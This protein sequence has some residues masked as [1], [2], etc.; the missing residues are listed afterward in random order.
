MPK[1]RSIMDDPLMRAAR[2]A[3]ETKSV[4]EPTGEA[5]TPTKMAG[6]DPEIQKLA[7][8]NPIFNHP[9]VKGTPADELRAF[10]SLGGWTPSVTHIMEASRDY[11]LYVNDD[12]A[13]PYVGDGFKHVQR[14]ALWLMRN[15]ADKIKVVALGG[16]LAE[17]G[18]Y[19]HGDVSCNDAISRLAAPYLNNVC[20]LDG[21]GHFGSR[22]APIEGIGAARYVSVRRSK[23]AESFLYSDLATV[24]LTDNYDGSNQQPVHFLPLIPIV[25]LN[26]ISGMG[27]G[28]STN[29]L[30]HKLTDIIDAT[31]AVMKGK[32]IKPLL[33][34]WERYDLD[35]K[36]LGEG[37]YEV[38]G[39][40]EKLDTSRARIYE[41]PPGMKVDDFRSKLIEM[42]EKGDIV[43]FVDRSTKNINIEIT[44]K[45][46]SI[47]DWNTT[48]LLQFFKLSEKM[49][50]RLVV[51]S[52]DGKSITRIA[53][54]DALIREFV[55][56]RLGWFENRYHHLR[57]KANIE[58][59]Y[60]YLVRAMIKGGFTKKLGTFANKAAVEAEVLGIAKKAKLAIDDS[61]VD[62]A[63]GLPTYRWTKEFESEVEAKIAEIEA[64]MAE[65]SDILSKP[66]RRKA[67]YLGEVEA[68]RKLRQ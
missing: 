49:T 24:P 40:I 60:W 45:R 65:Y 38:W 54:T 13:I 28:Y 17:T 23:A 61:S 14:V 43:K 8:I 22:L 30:P 64:D 16:S 41:L 58:L 18:L 12:R 9:I 48:R 42:E 29:I 47:S 11:S 57:E 1:K 36:S 4:V 56:W 5:S 68:L 33:P 37:K 52:W 46:G 20:L 53:D 26:G 67:I 6:D 19:V 25:L 32:P 21:D 34:H 39:K 31:I 35:V 55:E 10:L 62:R 15:R 51:R 2:M 66:E 7:K 50:E 27:V 3:K 59:Q 63:I 44:F